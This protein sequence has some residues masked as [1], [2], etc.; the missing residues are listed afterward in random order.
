MCQIYS[1]KICSIDRTMHEVYKPHVATSIPQTCLLR[2]FI[3]DEQRS[4]EEFVAGHININLRAV[5]TCV[6]LFIDDYFAA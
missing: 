2:S 5:T 1:Q 4:G 3:L 6:K